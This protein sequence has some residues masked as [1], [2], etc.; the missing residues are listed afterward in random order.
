[1]DVWQLLNER[2]S[3]PKVSA[4][5]PDAAQLERLLRAAVSAPDHGLLRPWRFLVLQGDDLLRFGDLL[6]TASRQS[7]P[8]LDEAA[9]ARIREKA[10]RAPMVIVAVAEVTEGHK[11][12]VVEQVMAT[13]CAVEHLMLAAHALGLGAMW[14]TGPLA[15]SEQVKAALGFAAKDEIVAFVYLGTPCAE[16]RPRPDADLA[17]V[18]RSLP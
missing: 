4:P 5:G 9:A 17:G 12:P 1:M 11:V 7:Q 15:Q 3:C 10:F 2:V 14:R 6:V 13:A 8:D 18:L 16:A